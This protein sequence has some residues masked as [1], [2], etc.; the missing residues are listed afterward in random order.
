MTN[1]V[2]VLELVSLPVATSVGSI[3]TITG[4]VVLIEDEAP[5][6]N[7]SG[8]WVVILVD[9]RSAGNFCSDNNTSGPAALFS[10]LDVKWRM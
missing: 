3:S 10:R 2:L 7:S 8:N 6:A 9:G 4:P 1:V 5:P